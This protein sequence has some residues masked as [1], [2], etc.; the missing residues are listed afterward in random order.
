[1]HKPVPKA[2]DLSPWNLVVGFLI[3]I[4]KRIG[5]LADVIQ[6]SCDCSAQRLLLKDIR[7]GDMI[8][9]QVIQQ[10]FCDRER[11]LNP[12]LIRILHAAIRTPSL[13]IVR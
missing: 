8:R 7:S 4:R 5:M 1:M 12:L 11:F 6:R 3:L 10:L 2:G 13:R 9:R